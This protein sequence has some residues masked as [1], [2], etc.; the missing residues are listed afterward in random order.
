MNTIERASRREALLN[1]RS[2]WEADWKVL[3]KHILPR[4]C[5]LEREGAQANQV[6]FDGASSK[7]AAASKRQF[8]IVILM[9]QWAQ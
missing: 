4:K 3:A 8:E 1:E 6:R 9:K 7:V 2:T 5:R